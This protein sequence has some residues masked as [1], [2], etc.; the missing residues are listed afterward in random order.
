MALDIKFYITYFIRKS[1]IFCTTL[2]TFLVELVLFGVIC[3]SQIGELIES[4][5][6]G[7]GLA[8]DSN[9]EIQDSNPTAWPLDFLFL[10]VSC[11]SL[12]GDRQ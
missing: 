4:N 2:I 12:S 6:N 3:E 5:H 11:S 10:G 9:T 8:L 7:K 1:F